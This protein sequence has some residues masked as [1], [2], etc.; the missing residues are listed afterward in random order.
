MRHVILGDGILATELVRASGW[1]QISRKSSKMDFANL[2]SYALLIEDYDVIINCIAYTDTYA[3]SK[4]LHWNINYK[5]VA[6]LTDFCV[7]KNKKLIHFSTDYVYE[8]S[9]E[10]A[11]EEDVPVHGKTWYAYT[12][13]LADAYIELKASKY[14]ILRGSHKLSPFTYK[15][16]WIDQVGNFDYIEV[17]AKEYLRLII[18]DAIGVYNVGTE[19]KTML[20]LAKNTNIDTVGA[21]APSHVPRNVSMNTLKSQNK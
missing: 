10:N 7:F 12:K 4:D 18:Q 17:M 19:L 5:G 14:L 20:D 9:V 3:A 8:N 16:A 13:L 11:T 21:F 6:E 1:D 2:D 15:Q